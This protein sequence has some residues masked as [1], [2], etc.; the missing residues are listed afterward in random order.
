MGKLSSTRV[1]QNF[2]CS[3]QTFKMF[4]FFLLLLL[5]TNTKGKSSGF[6]PAAQR[7]RW[8]SRPATPAFLSSYLDDSFI[9]SLVSQEKFGKCSLLLF[10]DKFDNGESVDRIL[11]NSASGFGAMK[12][13]YS[14]K[15]GSQALPVP[16]PMNVSSYQRTNKRCFIVVFITNDLQPGFMKQV[17]NMLTPVFL[18]LTR[19]DED[20]YIFK[21][22]PIH[23]QDILSMNELASRIKFKIAVG[24]WTSE[25]DNTEHLKLSTNLIV[26][27]VC[28]FC[29]GGNPKLIQLP[30]TQSNLPLMG[31]NY[32]PD[33]VLD[34]NGKILYLSIA[35]TQVKIEVDYPYEGLLNAKRGSWKSLFH[36]FLMVPCT[37]IQ[38]N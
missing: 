24:T 4:G 27:T 31:L 17:F 37:Y 29:N 25:N 21:T 26:S 19:K 18:P 11:S 3:H 10:Q 2:N 6:I 30:V 34:L 33:F 12:S 32:F 7:T 16:F 28:F 14:I 13:A 38:L 23:H 9:I 5:I 36:E 20:F 35:Y 1:S 22:N 8:P 15:Y